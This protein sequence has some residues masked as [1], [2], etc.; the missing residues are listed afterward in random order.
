MINDC[1]DD[2]YDGVFESTIYKNSN[3]GTLS[4]DFILTRL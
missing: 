4:R 1:G 3:D 2:Q